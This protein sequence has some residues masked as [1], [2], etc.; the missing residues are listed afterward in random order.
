MIREYEY[1]YESLLFHIMITMF[2]FVAEPATIPRMKAT[3]FPSYQ[4]DGFF[5]DF[6][7]V[8]GR[9]DLIIICVVEVF[10]DLPRFLFPRVGDFTDYYLVTHIGF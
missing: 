6:G 8:N 9:Y 10:Q 1:D 5:V 7:D 3:K 4:R 2:L